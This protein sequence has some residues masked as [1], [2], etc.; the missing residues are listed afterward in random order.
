M[1]FYND[2]QHLLRETSLIARFLRY[3][4]IDTTS[5]SSS[6]T[7][8]STEHQFSL[9][10]LLVEE[11][12]TLGLEDAAVDGNCYV[13]ATL[14]GNSQ[15]TIG[16]IAH[17]DTSS[18]S[19][20]KNVRP[21][22]TDNYDGLP[23]HLENGVVI[24][25]THTP[26]LNKCLGDTLISS[27]GSTLLGADDKAGI[28]IIMALAE[29][30]TKH[31]ELKHPTIR[32]G[33]TPDE[34]IG[35]GHER[36]PLEQFRADVAFTLDGSFD[37]EINIETFEAYSADVTFTGVATHPGKAKG[38]LVNALRYMGRFLD[39]LPMQLSPEQTEGREG[40][41]HP[42]DISGNASSCTC[43]L[44]IRDFQEEKVQELSREIEKIAAAVAAEDV[45]L[46]VEV[47]LKFSYPN[48]IR[49]LENRPEIATRLQRAVK[50]A[51]VEPN[52]QPIRGGTDG[53]NLSR[54]GLPTPN[55]FTGGLNFHSTN[56]CISTRS[57]GLALCTVLNLMQ[58][59]CED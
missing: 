4:Q 38:K 28:A 56:E 32:I 48:M 11:L 15:Q 45:R 22:L 3:V 20:G 17:L 8:P 59:Y 14:P 27:D 30:Y 18:A 43:H 6:S 49:F 13:T 10:R 51:G 47:E 41:I 52:L 9:A 33:F 31:P 2:P 29:F 36:F 5:D 40:F 23:I 44:I 21:V 50:E 42:S 16:L 34:E 58:L 37:G 39:R 57:M 53:S 26:E 19:P 46:K 55:I 12:Q 24:D 7:F 54:K 25:P 1:H 35:K